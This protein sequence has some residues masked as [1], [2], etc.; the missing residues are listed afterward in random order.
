MKWFP[1][2]LPRS[3]GGPVCSGVPVALTL[4]LNSF[5]H[6]DILLGYFQHSEGFAVCQSDSSGR[7]ALFRLES[8]LSMQSTMRL[9]PGQGNVADVGVSA[10]T[11]VHVFLAGTCGRLDPSVS[12]AGAKLAGIGRGVAVD[13]LMVMLSFPLVSGVLSMARVSE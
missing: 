6:R 8:L 10:H 9:S 4:T 12:S 2:L 3:A 13:W 7:A 5:W 1:V 11:V